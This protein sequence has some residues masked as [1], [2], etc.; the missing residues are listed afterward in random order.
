MIPL[1][2]IRI[3]IHQ[4][5]RTWF[6]FLSSGLNPSRSKNMIPLNDIR[7][8]IHPDLRILFLLISSGLDPPRSKNMI[9]FCNT[10]TTAMTGSKSLHG[11]PIEPKQNHNLFLV[12]VFKINVEQGQRSNC[13]ETNLLEPLRSCREPLRLCRD[14]RRSFEDPRRSWRDPRSEL[15]DRLVGRSKS[16]TS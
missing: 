1:N 11:G 9:P 13:A 14:P 6:L 16:K 3:Y 10:K 15:C 4:D 7:I 8:Y 5:L 2:I 12:N